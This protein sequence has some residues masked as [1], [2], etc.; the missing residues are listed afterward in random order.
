MTTRANSSLSF[1]SA[2]PSPAL[3]TA[4]RELE[5][6]WMSQAK[7]GKERS[8]QQREADPAL[9]D[10]IGTQAF[11][12]EICAEQLAAL[13]DAAPP[14]REQQDDTRPPS[15]REGGTT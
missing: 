1:V 3:R 10:L 8:D 13:L 2:D 12:F 5:K 11:T 7:R 6:R 15:P 14:S 4:L 9:A